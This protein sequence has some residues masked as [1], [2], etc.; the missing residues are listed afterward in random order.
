MVAMLKLRGGFKAYVAWFNRLYCMRMM[1]FMGSVAV[2][3]VEEL[4][5]KVWRLHVSFKMLAY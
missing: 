4:D 3:D 5:C 2:N 1:C